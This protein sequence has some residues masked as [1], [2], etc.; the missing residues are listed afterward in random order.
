MPDEKKSSDETI[1]DLIILT[2]CGMKTQ[3][4]FPDNL[5]RCPMTGC[6]KT[7]SNRL[8]IILH[9]KKRHAEKSI[10]C[11][12][13][14]APMCVPNDKDFENHYRRLHPDVEMPIR[15]VQKVK[16]ET[17]TENVCNFIPNINAFFKTNLRSN[18]Q[19]KSILQENNVNKSTANTNRKDAEVDDL[20]TL[21]GLGQVTYWRFPP[22]DKR[23]PVLKCQQ[24]LES[25]SLAI[26]HY[27]K[28]HANNSIFCRPCNKP[29][30]DINNLCIAINHFNINHPREKLPTYLLPSAPTKHPQKNHTKSQVKH[31]FK[32]YFIL[33]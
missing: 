33:N 32:T 7:Y 20:I 17:Q 14:N 16:Q 3:W 24:N 26:A 2:G 19:V 13:C 18:L 8:K 31:L 6:W 12:I 1:D 21:S 5:E 4:K 9:Y 25:R 23:C 28:Q 10:L 11:Y 22:N 15:F 27:R 29:L 30:H